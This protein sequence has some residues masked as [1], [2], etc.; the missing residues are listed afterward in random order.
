MQLFK[1][2][3]LMACLTFTL[4]SCQDRDS[5]SRDFLNSV[6][7][8]SVITGNPRQIFGPNA[9]DLALD[10][11]IQAKEWDK[12]FYMVNFA[13]PKAGAFRYQYLGEI[14]TA[15]GEYDNAIKVLDRAVE[16]GG[17]IYPRGL[18]L[19]ANVYEVIG[20]YDKALKDYVTLCTFTYG[21]HQNAARIFDQLGQTDSAL[22]YYRIALE[23]YPGDS[24]I[25]KKVS[26]LERRLQ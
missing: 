12:A 13:F 6:R 20:D 26:I 9:F 3:A 21:D 22:K 10:K 1:V 16:L 25:S 18:V 4:Q 19:R 5:L 23:L 11:A 24:D 8:S 15:K 7:D 17:T 14:Y 2:T